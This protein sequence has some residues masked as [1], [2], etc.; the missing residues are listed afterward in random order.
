VVEVLANSPAEKAGLFKTD[1]FILGSKD[2]PFIDLEDFT[3]T[4]RTSK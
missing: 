3:Q 4:M 1:D 2:G